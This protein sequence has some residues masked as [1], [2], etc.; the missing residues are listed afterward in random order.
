MGKPYFTKSQPSMRW[1]FGEYRSLIERQTRFAEEP[2]ILPMPPTQA[3]KDRAHERGSVGT[4][5]PPEDFKSA[6]IYVIVVVYGNDS[7][8]ADPIVLTHKTNTIATSNLIPI[9]TDLIVSARRVPIAL[10]R[11]NSARAS[12]KMNKLAKN[13]RV[14]HS[15][16]WR[17]GLMW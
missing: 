1:S 2:I 3:P 12:T 5:K 8:K 16:A 14:S 9:S 11:P 10:I 7:K 17:Y 13:N 6:R 15:T 4:P